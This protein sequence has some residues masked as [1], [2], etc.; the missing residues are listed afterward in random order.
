MAAPPAPR[1]RPGAVPVAALAGL[2]VLLALAALA[3]GRATPGGLRDHGP[4]HPVTPPPVP[5]PLWPD[6][7]PSPSPTPPGSG[8]AGATQAPPEPVPDLTVPGRDLT[9]VDV[10]ALL[11]K[12]PALTPE[13]RRT[14][15]TSTGSDARAPEIRAPEF[16]DLTG[17]GRPELITTV[18]T[19]G[20]VFLH[21]YTLVEDRVVPILSVQVQRTFNAATIGSDLVLYESTGVYV[22]TTSHYRWDGVRLVLLE[23]KDEGL[24]V[25][26]PTGPTGPDSLQ[27]PTATPKPA[28]TPSGPDVVGPRPAPGGAVPSPRAPEPTSRPSAPT[29]TPEPKR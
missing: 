8:S 26:P 16:R 7:A 21:V 12:D 3:F 4:A 2:V 22:R 10:R 29:V 11:T 28:A 19:P 25:L 1:R 17:D 24:G 14:L 9:A 27:T 18:T 15:G 20:P 6:L 13:E 23:R 5:R